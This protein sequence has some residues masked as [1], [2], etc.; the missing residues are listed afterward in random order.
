VIDSVEREAE[1]PALD[2]DSMLQMFDNTVPDAISQEMDIA[3]GKRG[4]SRKAKN[5][6]RK[7]IIV[8]GR[9]TL[10]ERGQVNCQTP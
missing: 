3:H 4:K 1:G 5:G 8:N 6:N 7:S 2:K 9:T 10:V